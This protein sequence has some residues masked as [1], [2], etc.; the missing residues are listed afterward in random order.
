MAY[1]SGDMFTGIFIA[2]FLLSLGAIAF[3][4]LRYA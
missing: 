3:A 4:Y 1:G 2:I